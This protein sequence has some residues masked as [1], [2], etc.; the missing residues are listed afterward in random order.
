M[1][2]RSEVISLEFLYID[3]NSM[4]VQYYVEHLEGIDN[5]DRPAVSEKKLEN[6]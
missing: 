3:L 1:A 6:I 4:E 5:F 2:S